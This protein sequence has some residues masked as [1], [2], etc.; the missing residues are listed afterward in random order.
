M[1]EIHD[2]LT[3]IREKFGVP[4]LAGAVV[5]GGVP[6]VFGAVGV[7]K[8]GDATPV[9]DAD[10][11]HLGSCTK[12]M[13]A[14]L[15]GVLVEEKRLRWE[16]TLVESLPDLAATMRPEWRAVTLDHL[17]CHRSGMTGRSAP[18]GKNLLDMH[19]LPGPPMEQRRAFVRMMLSEPPDAP[20]G[21]KYIYANTGF[22][23]AGHIAERATKTPWET[24]M[25]ERI[26]TPLGMK[27][28]GF[29]AMGTPGKIDQPWQHRTENGSAVPV[30][31]GP[32]S[33]NPAT[34]GPGGTVHCAMED[35]AK[36]VAVHVAARPRLLKSASTIAHL[37]TPRFG[38][39]YAFGW[40]V[41]ERG[42]GGGTVLTHNGSNT[43]NY[44]VTWLAPLKNFAVLAATNQGGDAMN[45]VC[46]AVAGALIGRYLNAP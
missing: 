25:R 30:G 26:F 19:R 24:L 34:I 4:A 2:I 8:I 46:D 27:S 6:H 22:A 40:Q 12:S 42:W 35:W 17:L 28:A 18:L 10:R 29:G 21:S 13:T 45:A 1:A 23:V 5:R 33:D 16:Q 9:T 41:T 38:G 3:P 11:F 44:A 14:T 36:Y 31:P 39:D 15:I 7:R 37:H 20:I 43:M 32:L